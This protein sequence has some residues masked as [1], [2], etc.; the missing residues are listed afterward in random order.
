MK[1]RHMAPN[2]WPLPFHTFPP[3]KKKKKKNL[4]PNKNLIFLPFLMNHTNIAKPLLYRFFDTNTQ[5][6]R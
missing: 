6:S 3:L 2:N 1:V 4:F 5:E